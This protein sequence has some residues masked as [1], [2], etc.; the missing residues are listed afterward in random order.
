M[1]AGISVG[2]NYRAKWAGEEFEVRVRGRGTAVAGT[3]VCS[4]LDTNRPIV[5]PVD[6]FLESLPFARPAYFEVGERWYG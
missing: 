3:W 4:R 2:S 1:L 5:L 6:A